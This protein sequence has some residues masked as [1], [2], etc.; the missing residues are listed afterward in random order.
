LPGQS[1]RRV[2]RQTTKRSTR[3]RSEKPIC[4]IMAPFGGWNDRYFEDVYCPAVEAAG[5]QPKRADDLYRP[6]A[7]V[8]DI[9]AFIKKSKVMLADVTGKNPN[10]FYELG[11]AHA[12][13]KPV[14]LVTRSIDDVPFDLRALRVIEYDVQD[15][16]WSELLVAKASKALR[17]VLAA[18]HEAVPPTFLRE[19]KG[20]EQ[21]SVTPLQRKLLAMQQQVDSL[22]RE[23]RSGG[24]SSEM[25][26]GPEEAEAVLSRYVNMGMPDRVIITRMERRGVPSGWLEKRLRELRMRSRRRPPRRVPVPAATAPDPGEPT[27]G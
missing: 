21:P 11:L 2:K 1:A 10:V 26:S 27:K 25:I 4:F 15:P 3:G 22:S 17:E 24:N 16:E 5:L 7:I 9:W 23:V 8:H 19:R 14:V 18:P 13:G 6:S 12:I 20:A